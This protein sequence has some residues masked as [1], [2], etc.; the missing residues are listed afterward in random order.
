M[1]YPTQNRFALLLE[2]LCLYAL[3]NAK[4]LRTFAGNASVYQF[5][6]RQIQPSFSES[7]I[8]ASLPTPP[9]QKAAG[10]A[11]RFLVD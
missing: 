4:P 1:H 5:C 8:S 9:K 10:L 11:R 7:K 2:M 6:L 3:S